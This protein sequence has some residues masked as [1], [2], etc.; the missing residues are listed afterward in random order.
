MKISDLPAPITASKADWL[1]G[2][3]WIGFTPTDDTLTAR[4]QCQSTIQRQ[5]SDG[6]VIEYIT[7]QFSEPNPGFENDPAYLAE[8]EAHRALAGRL[9]AVHKLRTTARSLETIL[10]K[11]EFKRVQDMWAQGGKRYRWSVAFPIVE[12]YEIVGRPK[13]K[14]VLGDAAYR[15]LYQRSSSTLRA[16]NDNERELVAKLDLHQTATPNA[17]I[18]IEDE[19]RLAEGS[20]IDARTQRLIDQDLAALEGT[21]EER[22]MQVRRRAA[23]K[24]DQFIRHRQKTGALICDECGFDPTCL[25][26]PQQIRPRSLLDVHHKNPLDEGVRYTTIADLRCCA[27]HVIG[28]STRGCASPRGGSLSNKTELQLEKIFTL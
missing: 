23:W 7:E 3:T 28:L 25:F 15:R 21:T 10:G 22:R 1:A 6:Y 13:A 20:E 19:F 24:A 12:S 2:T 14:D 9:V 5:F 18:G 17:W 16:L 11:A 26:S 8:R 27:R 4:N